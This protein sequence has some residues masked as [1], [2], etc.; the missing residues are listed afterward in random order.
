MRNVNETN[1]KQLIVTGENETVEFMQPVS[2]LLARTVVAFANTKGGIVVIGYDERNN[3]VVGVQPPIEG[4]VRNILKAYLHLCDIYFVEYEQ[5][6]VLIIEVSEANYTV[7]LKGKIYYREGKSDKSIDLD[8]TEKLMGI[9]RSSIKGLTLSELSDQTEIGKTGIKNILESPVMSGQ[10]AADVVGNKKYYAPSAK[11]LPS[12][13]DIRNIEDIHAKDDLISYLENKFRRIDGKKMLHQ[14][15]SIRT[16]INIIRSHEFYLGSPSNMNDVLEYN[17][18]NS[19]NWDDLFFTCF[20]ENEAESIAMWSQYAQPWDDGIRLSVSVEKIKEWFNSVSAVDSA[21]PG[22]KEKDGRFQLGPNRFIKSIHM[23]AYTNEDDISDTNEKVIVSVGKA[24]TD[25]LEKLNGEERL[26]GYIK[27]TAWSYEKEIRFRIQIENEHDDT[28]GN[29]IK[30]IRIAIPDGV[31]KSMVIMKG[32]RVPEDSEEW[33]ELTDL[34][35]AE[36]L[37]LPKESIF[38]GKLQN[39]ACDRCKP[40]QEYR[41]AHHISAN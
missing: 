24:E 13:K 40:N 41:K 18:F 34:L 4:E 28:S 27:N 29:K 21:D 15:T 39:M 19:R 14:Y 22:T 37:D 2:P 38:K 26:C 16:A 36:G 1:I 32:P 9:V 35:K 17:N 20:M 12:R 31:I 6:Q 11:K 30:G 3:T 23:V 7:S 5:K 25:K 10:L 33:K 8:D